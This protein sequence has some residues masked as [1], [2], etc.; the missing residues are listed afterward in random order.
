MF[1]QLSVAFLLAVSSLHAQSAA[2]MGFEDSY[3]LM[4]ETGEY[5][6]EVMFN[7]APS[8]HHALGVEVMH[9]SPKGMRATTMTGINYTGLIQRWNLPS[10]QGNV[11]F[12]GSVGEARGLH[13]GFSYSPSVQFDYE[14]TRLYFLA[15]MRMLRAPGMNNDM[16]AVQGGFSFYEADFDETQPWFV[17]EA[18]A[19]KNFNPSLQVTPALR[20]INKNYFLELGITNPFNKSERAPRLNL[21]FTY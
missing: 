8:I 2:L 16:A 10:A 13:H 7:Y 1:K 12:M 20:L 18:K 14:T 9:M 5:N 15:K 4:T 11:W 21:M 19:T 6:Q 17:L 3:M